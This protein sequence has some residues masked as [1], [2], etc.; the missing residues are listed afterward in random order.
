M[1]MKNLGF[2]D[3]VTAGVVTTAALPLIKGFFGGGTNYANNFSKQAGTGKK[4][5][6]EE[7]NAYY[8]RSK[9]LGIPA[10][11]LAQEEAKGIRRDAQGAI[12]PAGGYQ[13][14]SAPR[15]L[16]SPQPGVV[17]YVAPQYATSP[18]LAPSP[19][20]SS[21]YAFPSPYQQPPVQQGVQSIPP[22]VWMAG[23]GAVIAFMTLS[24]GR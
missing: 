1:K 17:P 10:V 22:W 14:A 15:P 7:A 11:Q 16:F 24:R 6:Q 20:P 21:Q 4:Y 8:S 5:L 23:A 3:P 2:V 9:Q 13:P 19:Y 12:A 18:Y